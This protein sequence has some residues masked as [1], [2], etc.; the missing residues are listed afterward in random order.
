VTHIECL[1]FAQ[2]FAKQASKMPAALASAEKKLRD[3]RKSQYQVNQ[4]ATDGLAKENQKLKEQMGKMQMDS[5]KMQ[6]TVQK[7]QLDAH[8]QNIQSQIKAQAAQAANAGLPTQGPTPPPAQ[9]AYQGMPG[10]LPP[11]EQAK[12]DKAQGRGQATAGAGAAV[13]PS[14]VGIEPPGQSGQGLG[15][16]V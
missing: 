1:L 6:M 10:T 12:Q 3:I 14:L 5:Q 4:K 15:V 7:I 13:N 8:K 9:A 16:A 2:A 11:E